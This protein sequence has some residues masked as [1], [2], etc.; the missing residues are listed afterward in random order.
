[1]SDTSK[2]ITSA[3]VA[4]SINLG[5]LLDIFRSLQKRLECLSIGIILGGCVFSRKNKPKSSNPQK[6]IFLMTSP[7]Y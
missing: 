1:M 2:L 5:R 4:E 7:G 3:E 6:I